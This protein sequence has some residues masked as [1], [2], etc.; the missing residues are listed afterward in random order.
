MKPS[1]SSR[2]SGPAAV[3]LAWSIPVLLALYAG[4]GYWLGGLAGHRLAGLLVGWG[5]G[6]GAVIYEIVKSPRR[7]GG[8]EGGTGP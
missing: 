3:G 7:S 8:P 1:S 5:A 6:M 2:P 4:L